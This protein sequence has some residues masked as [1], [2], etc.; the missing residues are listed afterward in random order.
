MIPHIVR[1]VKREI[2]FF[3]RIY[4]NITENTKCTRNHST[5]WRGLRPPPFPFA[6][7]IARELHAFNCVS[8]FRN[9]VLNLLR[10]SVRKGAAGF[11]VD[12]NEIRKEYIQGGVSYRELAAKY[13][14]P[15]KNLARR[16]K[17][18]NWVELRKQSDHK[19]ATKTVDSVAMQNGGTPYHRYYGLTDWRYIQGLLR[20]HHST[21]AGGC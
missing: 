9:R 21:G 17:D 20:E 3:F 6:R 14:V 1:H 15:L 4:L 12:W 11:V 7:G 18:E 5:N 16:A 8:G 19:A 13:G 10:W 2:E